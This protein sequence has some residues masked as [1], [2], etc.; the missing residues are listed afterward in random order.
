MLTIKG[1]SLA[2]SGPITSTIRVG[3]GHYT[4]VFLALLWAGFW[5]GKGRSDVNGESFHQRFLLDCDGDR[6][7]MGMGMVSW[8]RGYK[9]RFAGATSTI[10]YNTTVEI[11]S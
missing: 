11:S 6:S 5:R 2:L 9:G 8:R 7:L 4:G 3:Y 1:G 10:Q